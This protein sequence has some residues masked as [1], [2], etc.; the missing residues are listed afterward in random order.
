MDDELSRFEEHFDLTYANE[1]ASYYILLLEVGK[2]RV[3]ALWYHTTKNLI[4]GFASYPYSG[5][6]QL[7]LA[8]HPYL[9]SEFK[10]VIITLDEPNFA[11]NPSSLVES[12]F[13]T[14]AM[15]GNNALTEKESTLSVN[16]INMRARVDFKIDIESEINIKNAISHGKILPHIAPRIEHEL[17]LAKK[18]PNKNFL[19]AHVGDEQIDIRIYKGGKLA[20][21]NSFYQTGAEDIVYYIL[22]SGEVLEL[23]PEQEQLLISGET[24][25]GHEHWMLL[26]KYWRNIS[27]SEPL[28]RIEI[29]DKISSVFDARFNY[30][31]HSLLCAS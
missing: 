27:L 6:M 31:T 18:Q 9:A 8:T 19:S 25:I 1:P 14:Y 5:N 30:L 28:D 17:N 4:T 24:K 2:T 16:L 23:N 11:V 26:S 10:E 12:N 15:L 29:S 20:M 22:F 7:L 3:K 13:S 21:A